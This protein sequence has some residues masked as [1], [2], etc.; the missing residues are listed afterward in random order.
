MGLKEVLVVVAP[1]QRGQGQVRFG[2]F[3]EIQVIK[4]PKAYS[5]VGFSQRT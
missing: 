3:F 2:P 1:T 4:V 5:G